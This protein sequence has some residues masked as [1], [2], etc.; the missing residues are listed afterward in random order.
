V[1]S[2]SGELGRFGGGF[3]LKVGHLQQ[4][5]EHVEPKPS[6]EHCQFAGDIRRIGCE[7]L[8]IVRLANSRG[9]G[10]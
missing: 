1:F 6:G 9:L 7:S 10:D 8:A 4:V 3:G 5:G 2:L